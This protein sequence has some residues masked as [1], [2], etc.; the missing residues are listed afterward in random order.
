VRGDEEQKGEVIMF[1]DSTLR[2]IRYLAPD[3]EE[4]A[5]KLLATLPSG[6]ERNVPRQCRHS[7]GSLSRLALAHALLEL[8]MPGGTLP[9]HAVRAL[10]V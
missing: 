6:W 3:K 10:A 7:D 9:S 2:Y 5:G 1:H 4:E 8:L